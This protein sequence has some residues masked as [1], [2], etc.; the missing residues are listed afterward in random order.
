[1]GATETKKLS[2]TEMV[3]Q[4]VL[5]IKDYRKGASRPAIKNYVEDTYSKV[6]TPAALR[7]AIKGLVDNG[8]LT[9]E[10]QRFKLDQEKRKELR[11]PAP[12]PKKK[13]VVKK[14]AKKKAK[15]K[16]KKKTKKKATNKKTAKKS[17]KKTT[18]K[19]GKKTTKKKTTKKKSPKKA[20][21]KKGKKV[22]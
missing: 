14:K 5:N 2:Y 17:T 4:A 21:T 16:T 19:K 15:K 22:A 12:K 20:G 11:K 6:T 18:K 3:L 9:Q 10:G 8:T 7:R 1:M 13:K